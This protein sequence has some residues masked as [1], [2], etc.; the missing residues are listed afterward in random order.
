[1][2]TV[3]PLLAHDANAR[4]VVVIGGAVIIIPP[5]IR[6]WRQGLHVDRYRIQVLPLQ[7]VDVSPANVRRIRLEDYTVR[8]VMVG[9]AVPVYPRAPL[10]GHVR[11]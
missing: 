5:E 1:M 8:Q 9:V 6:T 7:E 4:N 2:S 11:Q 3:V 10:L